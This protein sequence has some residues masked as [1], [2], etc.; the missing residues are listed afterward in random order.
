[1]NGL[2]RNV[3]HVNESYYIN[4]KRHK[5]QRRHRLAFSPEAARPGAASRFPP[6]T[7]ALMHFP[8]VLAD[9]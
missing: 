2:A 1:M 3:R 8:P 5:C 6:V 9:E 4:T 7:S